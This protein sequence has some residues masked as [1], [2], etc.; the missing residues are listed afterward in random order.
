M[1]PIL[2]L[3]ILP[4]TAWLG[5]LQSF[6]SLP[7]ADPLRLVT[8]STLLGTLTVFVYRLGVWR[9]EMENTKHNVGAELKT[10]REEAAKSF[11]ELNRRLE[12]I[13]HLV[14]AEL[15][16]SE[17]VVRWQR[18][19]ERRLQRLELPTTEATR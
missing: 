2:T 11:A 8:L 13:D 6:Q 14:S 3:A 7:L 1:R 16:R 4:I 17:R 9:Q 18:R 10:G 15:E 12:A 5:A 19:T